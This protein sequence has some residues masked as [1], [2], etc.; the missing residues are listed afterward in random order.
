MF[1]KW[2]TSESTR[3]AAL[4]EGQVTPDSSRCVQCGICT[5]NCPIAIDVRRHAWTGQPVTRSECLT[6]GDCVQRCPRGVLR[7]ERSEL[8]SPRKA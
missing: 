2:F 3:R 8:G 4:F 5:Y 7:F 1:K 6:C